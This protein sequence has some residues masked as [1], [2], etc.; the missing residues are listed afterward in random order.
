MHEL[1]NEKIFEPLNI[2]R[3]DSATKLKN[4]IQGHRLDHERGILEFPLSVDW[5]DF[6]EGS[7]SGGWLAMKDLVAIAA[8]VIGGR[9][10][11]MQVREWMFNKSMAGQYQH[12]EK[13]S[14]PAM[15][16]FNLGCMY[17]ND[18]T[19]G[20]AAISAGQCSAVRLNPERKTVIAVGVNS[21]NIGL[22][23][24]CIR[25]LLDALH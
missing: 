16:G 20:A 3:H 6:W 2:D 14:E 8:G 4:E 10:L 1:L 19:W 7:L 17:F 24:T 11:S 15:R 9:I 22:R 12:A 23:D 5:C 25:M 21:E 13:T 18:G